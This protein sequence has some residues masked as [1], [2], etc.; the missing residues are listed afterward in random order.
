MKHAPDS[1]DADP[2]TPEAK[3]QCRNDPSSDGDDTIVVDE[4]GELLTEN[5]KQQSQNAEPSKVAQPKKIEQPKTIVS[6]DKNN[7]ESDKD[8]SLAA[9]YAALVRL[10][11]H[12]IDIRAASFEH[13]CAE[14][15]K[16]HQATVNNAIQKPLMALK[17]KSDLEIV[18][19]RNS[20]WLPSVSHELVADNVPRAATKIALRRV[21]AS[22]FKLTVV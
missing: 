13:S 5:G 19:L 6:D 2:A 21:N 3:R 22:Y 1:G 20:Q 8:K 17:K 18:K 12:S 9:L 4:N 14:Q 11:R 10:Q 15:L 7:D 16:L